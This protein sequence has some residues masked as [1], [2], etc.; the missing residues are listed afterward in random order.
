MS[1]DLNIDIM[2]QSYEFYMTKFDQQLKSAGYDYRGLRSS[3]QWLELCD[4][5]DKQIID[6]NILKEL[7][8]TLLN[9]ELSAF[10]EW[11]NQLDELKYKSLENKWA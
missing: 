1:N 4:K 9:A 3:T 5:V 7:K 11:L 6:Q 10:N 8:S 2:D